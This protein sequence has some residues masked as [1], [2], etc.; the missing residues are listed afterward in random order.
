MTLMSMWIVGA[1]DQLSIGTIGGR[2]GGM[3]DPPQPPGVKRKSGRG[4]GGNGIGGPRRRKIGRIVGP[5]V[6][7]GVPG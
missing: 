2:G 7:K 6:G 3:G 5:G 1:S 4:P